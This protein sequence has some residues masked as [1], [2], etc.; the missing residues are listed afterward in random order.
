MG[1]PEFAVPIFEAIRKN[2]KVIAVVSQPD[3]PVGRQQ[4]KI[5]TPTKTWASKHNIK[6]LQ[7]EKVITLYDELVKE[8]FDLILT[9]AFGQLI[10]KSILELPKVMPL[11]LHASLL[12]K[13]RGAAPIQ[14]A[15]LNGDTT[16]GVCLMKM[17]ERMDAGEVFACFQTDITGK[18]YTECLDILVKGIEK[19]IV[20]WL[21]QLLLKQLLPT[22]QDESLVSLAPKITTKDCEIFLTDKVET[23]TRK[24]LAFNLSPGAFINLGNVRIKLFKAAHFSIKNALKIEFMDGSLWFYEYQRAGKKI[25]KIPLPDSVYSVTL[26]SR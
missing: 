25:V 16:T 22:P 6:C 8:E 24:L 7:S 9:F 13:Y 2:F 26:E 12:P 19:N 4:E 15:I 18:N 11:N 14:H 17:V 23:V 20:F 21:Q 10:P 5:N 1:T 3:K